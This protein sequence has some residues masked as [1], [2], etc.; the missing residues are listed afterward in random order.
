M[1]ESVGDV[2]RV[3]GEIASLWR[4][5]WVRPRLG[6][7]S[8]ASVVFREHQMGTRSPLGGNFTDGA[9]CGLLAFLGVLP[10]LGLSLA[11]CRSRSALNAWS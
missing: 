8:S 11:A 4:E 5:L 2:A 6:E 1:G 7:S 10:V 9:A 3:S